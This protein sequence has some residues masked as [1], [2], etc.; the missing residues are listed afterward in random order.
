MPILLKSADEL[1]KMHRAGLIVWDVLTALRDMVRPG[2][3][4]MDL[5][6][7]A[8]ERMAKHPGRAAFKGYRGYPCALCASVNQEVEHALRRRNPVHHFLVDRGAQRARVTA[9]SL[10]RRAARM[11]RHALDGE[12]LQVHRREARA[13][14][15]AQGRQDVPDNQA[16]TM[17]LSE[18]I[19]RLQLDGHR[20]TGHGEKYPAPARSPLAHPPKH[21]HPAT[22]PG[23]GN[24]R[25]AAR[26]AVHTSPTARRSLLRDHRAGPAT[27]RRR[28]RNDRKPSARGH[29]RCKSRRKLCTCAAP[30]AAATALFCPR[31]SAEPEA[32]ACSAT[33]TTSPGFP[34][35]RW[36]SGTHPERILLR[37][38]AVRCALRPC[39]SRSRREP[40]RLAPS[41]AWPAS[42]AGC[43]APHGRGTCPQSRDAEHRSA[44]QSLSP[45]C[46][47]PLPEAR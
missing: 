33:S 45:E 12:F 22:R 9:I 15:V 5:E 41:P 24:R 34:P 14:H 38:R 7:F 43:R 2:L 13:N 44:G 40:S 27:R 20:S 25:S 26:S 8:V 46:L 29:R 19:G 30:S 28:Y 21:P 17:H 3:T 37:S 23:P 6:K 16:G 32:A 36:F 1:A 47:C 42:P 31:Q 39:P 35:E 4:T 10:E 18:L 11:L